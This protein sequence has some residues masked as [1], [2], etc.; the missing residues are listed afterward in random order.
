MIVLERKGG[1]CMEMVKIYCPKCGKWLFEAAENASGTISAYCK[2]C[3]EP[4]RVE[5][6]GKS[7]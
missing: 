3:G 7:E 1:A 6:K 5:L 4:V 2:R